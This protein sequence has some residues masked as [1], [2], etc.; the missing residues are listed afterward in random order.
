MS[1]LQEELVKAMTPPAPGLKT[2]GPG[3]Y[4]SVRSV[5]EIRADLVRAGELQPPPPPPPAVPPTQ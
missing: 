3:L 4:V 1:T 5:A 2:L